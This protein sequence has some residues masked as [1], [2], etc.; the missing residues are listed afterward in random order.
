MVFAGLLMECASDA[1]EEFSPVSGIR[2][3]LRMPPAP[4]LLLHVHHH[5]L[6]V[7]EELRVVL[8]IGEELM[9]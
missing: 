5:V 2:K 1:S 7:E 8:E 6:A 3:T 9:F 4:Y